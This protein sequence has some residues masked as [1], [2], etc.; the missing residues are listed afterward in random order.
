MACS[1]EVEIGQDIL[2][3]SRTGRAHCICID[4]SH[5]ERFITTCIVYVFYFSEYICVMYVCRQISPVKYS[6][7]SSVERQILIDC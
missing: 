3:T 2:I 4:Q 1:S 5:N 6:Q 7:E